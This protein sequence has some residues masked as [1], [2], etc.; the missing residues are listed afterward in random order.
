MGQKSCERCRKRAAVG[1]ISCC[2]ECFCEIIEKRVSRSLGSFAKRSRGEV[3]VACGVRTRVESVVARHI[4]ARLKAGARVKLVA[5]ARVKRDVVT[6]ESADGVAAMFVEALA[7]KNGKFS[8]GRSL[9][10]S[11]SEMEL[12][13]YASMKNLKY[14]PAKKGI[15]LVKSGLQEL[16]EKY[17]GTVESLVKSGRNLWMLKAKK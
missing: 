13:L 5:R 7:G 3:L 2:R 11:V 14:E 17:P 6:T 9:F 8:S 15:G 12:G 10:E 4:V 1:G 16:Q